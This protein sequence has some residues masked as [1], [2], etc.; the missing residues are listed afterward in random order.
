M[1]HEPRLGVI[2]S[3]RL[4][5]L[6]TCSGTRSMGNLV[7]RALV[8]PKMPH[9]AKVDYRSKPYSYDSGLHMSAKTNTHTHTHTNYKSILLDRSEPCMQIKELGQAELD[10]NP[11][12]KV[13]FL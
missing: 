9:V 10:Q 2:Q 6:Q 3:R 13:M 1:D 5:E 12:P 7:M 8:F 4:A 11:K